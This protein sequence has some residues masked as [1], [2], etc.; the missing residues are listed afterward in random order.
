MIA[1]TGLRL[2]AC[3]PKDDVYYL[4]TAVSLGIALTLPLFAPASKEWFATL[5]PLARLMLSN[6]VVLAVTL[7]VT[8]NGVLGAVL[9]RSPAV[10]T[11]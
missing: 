3:G 5:P 11:S 7:G 2:L 9:R 10:T 6:G 1:A 8:L 4:T